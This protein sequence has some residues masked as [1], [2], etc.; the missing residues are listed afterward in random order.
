MPGA[1]VVDVIEID[2]LKGLNIEAIAAE[3]DLLSAK[4]LRV[5]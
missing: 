2:R 4:R 5:F 3:S 1:G